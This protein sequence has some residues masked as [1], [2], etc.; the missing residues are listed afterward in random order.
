[1]TYGDGDV[2]SKNKSDRQGEMQN[3]TDKTGNAGLWLL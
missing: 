2:V 3:E 1:M